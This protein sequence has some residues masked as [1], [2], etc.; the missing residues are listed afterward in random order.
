MA[1]YN[2]AKVP[3]S[4]RITRLVEHLYAKMPEIESARA[5][6]LTESYRQTEDEPEVMRK[7]KAFAHILDHIP[8]IIREEE[9]IVGSSTIAPRG[10]QTFRSSPL[11][12]WNRSLTRW[13]PERRIPS[14]YRN[15][16]KRRSP[17]RT[18]TGRKDHQRAG[19]ILHGAG[20]I[21]GHGP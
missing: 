11:S 16:R 5:V 15:R 8:I 13:P 6:L 4:E 14:T 7:A 2:S 20:D 12:G 18:S 17:R 9:L 3:K 21:A 19:H 10:C 1:K